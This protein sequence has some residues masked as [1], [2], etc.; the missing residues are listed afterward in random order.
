MT[1]SR[2]LQILSVV[3]IALPLAAQDAALFDAV[4]N[5]DLKALK[6]GLPAGANAKNAKSVPLIMQAAAFGS[7]ESLRMIVDAGADVNAKNSF[8]AT[9]L[10]WAA[11]DPAKARLLVEHGAN[12]N[13]ASKQGRTPL[14]I[15]AANPSGA[16]TVKLLLDKGANLNAKDSF[17][18]TALFDAASSG[19]TEGARLLI[20]KGADANGADMASRSPLAMAAGNSNLPLVKLLLSKGADVNLAN[21]FAGKVKFGNIQLIGLTPLMVAAPYSSPQLIKT[22]LDAGA[23]VNLKDCRGMTALMLAVASETQDV[24]VA[25]L[26]IKAGADVNAK[27]EVGETALDWALKF[28]NKDVIGAL[29]SAGAQ[30]AAVYKTP[31]RKSPGDPPA[32]G[33]SIEKSVALLQ[34][35]STEFFKQSGC[36]GCHHQPAT[37]MAVAA[38]RSAGYH[39]DESAIRE[40]LGVARGGAQQEAEFL[41]QRIDG[42]AGPDIHVAML[43]VMHHYDY[44]PDVLTDTMVFNIAALQRANGS[45]YLGDVA[46]APM[47]ESTISRTAMTARMLKAYAIP[48][49]QAEFDERVARARTFLLESKAKTND[50]FALRLLGLVWTG[51][52]KAEIAK[53]GHAL[54]AR[55]KSDGGWAQ[56]ANLASDAFATGQALTA[57]HQSGVMKPTDPAYVRGAKYL[58]S[59]QFADCSWYVRSRAPKFQPYFQS[60]FPFDHDQ[61]ISAT[62]TSWAVAALAPAGNSLT[63]DS[64]Q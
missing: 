39:V 51:A 50:E 30:T 42:P 43:L 34:S 22:L 7:I 33:R 45:W 6:A 9:A 4:R 10:L 52:S 18:V 49:R 23:K 19:N 24:E 27:S 12:V 8:D 61:W 14:M 57:L 63:A 59:T 54:A 20:E 17:G 40:Q 5:N 46:R 29:R 3:T 11:G 64:R 36:L 56:N 21:T 16:D 35:S 53:A 62:A 26:L 41:L 48:A 38:A 58:L 44:K 37:S 2:V 60:G 1:K 13:V 28:G 47:E 55:Q 32:V 25:R 31:E 15:A